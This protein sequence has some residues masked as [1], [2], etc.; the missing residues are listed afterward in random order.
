MKAQQYRLDIRFDD[1]L[2]EA[3]FTAIPN[4]LLQHYKELGLSD[5]QV[6]WVIHLLRFKWSKAA[7]HPRQGNIPMACS[8]ATR[9]KYARELRAAGLLFTRRIYYTNETAPKP[10]LAGRLNA[11]EYHLD[12]L[13]HNLIRL[14]RSESPD[15]FEIELP[16]DV[17]NKTATG[18]YHDVPDDIKAACER[19]VADQNDGSL[20][21]S[22]I[23]NPDSRPTMKKTDSRSTV[24][25]TD[26]RSTIR[27]ATSRKTDSRSTIRKATSR[28]TDRHK[29]DSCIK[30]ET[31][32]AEKEEASEK[33]K[34]IHS[35][36]TSISKQLLLEYGI[37]EPVLTELSDTEPN[38][39]RSWLVYLR[40]Q[41]FEG[42]QGYLINRLRNGQLPPPPF[43]K[44]GSLTEDQISVIEEV[45]RDR[46]WTSQWNVDDL[47][48]AGIDEDI[49]E[50]WYQA[51]LS[52]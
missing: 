8:E 16:S 21:L 15:T 20:L 14:A 25:K 47:E 1:E 13:F 23:R 6:L 49:A 2:L 10:E 52:E 31:K 4:L 42:K 40:T 11:L 5:G 38:T 22:T 41:N 44:L 19:Y 48:E 34:A 26:S 3:G 50:L 37:N 28:K 33:E 36:S 35:T 46:Q 32:E 39:I 51:L 29:E 18:F 24:R 30:E 43:P 12:S 7:P 17:V 45:A 27:K 9:R